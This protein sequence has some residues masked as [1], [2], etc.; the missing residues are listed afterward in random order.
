[1]GFAAVG[2]DMYVDELVHTIHAYIDVVITI[3]SVTNI[4][5]ASVQNTYSLVKEVGIITFVTRTK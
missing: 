4:A 1:M 2:A 5:V 3:D